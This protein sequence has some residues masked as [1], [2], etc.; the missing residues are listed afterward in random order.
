MPTVYRLYLPCVTKPAIIRYTSNISSKRWQFRHIQFENVILIIEK[1]SNSQSRKNRLEY[2][3]ENDFT[4]LMYSLRS[5][6]KPAVSKIK[7]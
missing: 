6:F 7:L 4:E 5:L 3:F 1:V 2:W